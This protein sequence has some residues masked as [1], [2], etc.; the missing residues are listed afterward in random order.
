MKRNA[1]TILAGKCQ[2]KRSLGDVDVE[3]RKILKLVLKEADRRVWN[4]FIWFRTETAW[5]SCEQRIN[6]WVQ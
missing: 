6:F 2:G 1:H 3:R 4:G 5:G